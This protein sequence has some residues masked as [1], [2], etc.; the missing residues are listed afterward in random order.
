MANV[1]ILTENG[2]VLSGEIRNE[3]EGIVNEELENIT[4]ITDLV[5]KNKVSL[6]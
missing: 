6:F 5:V 4:A 1:D 2:V 3:I